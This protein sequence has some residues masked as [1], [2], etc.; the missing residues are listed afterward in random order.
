MN[1]STN[2]KAA[3]ITSSFEETMTAVMTG[4]LLNQLILPIK[5]LFIFLAFV[6]SV[7]NTTIHRMMDFKNRTEQITSTLCGSLLLCVVF[8]FLDLLTT[9]QFTGCSISKKDQNKMP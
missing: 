4:D 5:S 1:R 6:F 7:F 3:F 2:K 9:Q 8:V